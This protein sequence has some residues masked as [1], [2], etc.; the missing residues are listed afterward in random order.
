[1]ESS[2]GVR[3]NEQKLLQRAQLGILSSAGSLQ[4]ANKSCKITSESLGVSILACL[5]LLLGFDAKYELLIR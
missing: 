4:T 5:G 1:M 2:S 3:V